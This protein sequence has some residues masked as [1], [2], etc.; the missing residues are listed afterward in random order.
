MI[1]KSFLMSLVS[2]AV[3]VPASVQAGSAPTQL[4]GKSVTVDWT[5]TREQ[6]VED[7]P[8]VTT[9]LHLT[10][11]KIYVS[12]SG[13]LFSELTRVNQRTRGRTPSATGQQGPG[14]KASSRGA[15]RVVHFE[16]GSLIV[17]QQRGDIGA[18][19]VTVNFG[20]NYT[21]CTATL[22]EG[23]SGAGPIHTTGMI[24]GHSV[25]IYSM[26]VST[27]KCSISEGPAFIGQ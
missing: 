23:K 9:Q 20:S 11:L 14:D 22:I 10:N 3:L 6:R 7:D 17:D 1:Y 4:L 19:R 8:H 27:P 2:L 12:S 13:R 18:R 5:E 26:Q 15:P 21:T 24:S 16:G 25:T